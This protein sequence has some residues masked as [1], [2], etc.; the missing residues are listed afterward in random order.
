MRAGRVRIRKRLVGGAAMLAAMLFAA[1]AALA[2][3]PAYAPLNQPGPPLTV[4]MPLL[5][6]SLYCEPSVAHAKV[7]PVLLN[8]AT[9][10]TPEENYSWNWELGLPK[11]GIPWCAY[12]SPNDTLNNIETSGEYLVYAIRTMY[13]LAGRKI[14]V[15]GHSQGGMSMRWPLRFWPD[16]RAMVKSVIG[17]SGSNHGTT[18]LTASQCAA[19]GCPPA[20]WQQTY[21]SPFIEA[22]NSY[23]E[24]F[25]GISYTEIWTHTDEVVDP[26]G[27]AAT[28]S[29]ALHTG[30]GRITN[31]PTQQI[32]P[33]DV[34]EHLTIGTIDP[35][36]YAIAVNALTHAAPANLSEIPKSVCS[37]V[38][39]PQINPANLN[40]GLEIL[41]AAPGL[42][43]VELGPIATLATGAPV[44]YSEPPLACYV[45]A[46][47][48]GADAPRL[49]LRISPRVGA[50]GH[51][52]RAYVLVREGS[53][54][55]PVPDVTV[56]LGGARAVTSNAGIATLYPIL[57]AG[58]HLTARARRQGCDPA[59]ARVTVG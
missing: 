29:A 52:V 20:D 6:A 27:S 42:T 22:L 12:T 47:C 26:N 23:A 46:T 30:A 10:V 53:A 43:S 38:V 1:P 18:M 16:T 5:K 9:G 7:T 45:Y 44:L 14:D 2:G 25:A 21:Q 19:I 37:E 15:M 28:A 40:A 33:L 41:E 55:D 17:F 51:A 49:L 56:T 32:C 50:G 3:T 59:S 36:A 13:T 8:P 48:T 11:L 35:V 58:Q 54:L 34:Y 4:P 31:V 24:T 57:R 39:S